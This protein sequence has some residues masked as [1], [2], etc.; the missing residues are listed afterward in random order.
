MKATNTQKIYESYNVELA[1]EYIK[2]VKLSNFT[3]IY[4]LINEENNEMDNLAQKICCIN[5]L[6]PGLV[7]VVA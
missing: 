1:A 3:E 7:T 4:S 5:N 2:S 6:L